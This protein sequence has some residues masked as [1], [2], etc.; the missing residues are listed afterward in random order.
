MPYLYGPNNLRASIKSARREL[1]QS[2]IS[3]DNSEGDIVVT[4]S[5]L[6][7]EESKTMSASPHSWYRSM[8]HSVGSS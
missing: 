1:S 6:V 3:Q 2:G 5:I 7:S 8:P 4:Q